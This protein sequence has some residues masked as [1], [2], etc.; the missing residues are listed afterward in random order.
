MGETTG[1]RYWQKTS[2]W[3]STAG[4]ESTKDAA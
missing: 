1:G 2:G 3:S 4:L